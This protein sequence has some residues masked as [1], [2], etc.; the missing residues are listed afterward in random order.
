LYSQRDQHLPP[1]VW[2]RAGQKFQQLVAKVRMF[3]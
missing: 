2:Q 1:T 3:L